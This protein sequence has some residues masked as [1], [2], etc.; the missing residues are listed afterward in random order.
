MKNGRGGNASET[1]YF[2]IK[3]GLPHQAGVANYRMVAQIIP[4]FLKASMLRSVATKEGRWFSSI[5]SL[6]YPDDI[7]SDHRCPLEDGGTTGP[8]YD[9]PSNAITDVPRSTSYWRFFMCSTY[10]VTKVIVF[11]RYLLIYQRM[12]IPQC[13]YLKVKCYVDTR[14]LIH[15][16]VG[17]GRGRNEETCYLEDTDAYL[18]LI[19]FFEQIYSVKEGDLAA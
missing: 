15:V 12:Y 10:S 7:A 1:P 5:P 18:S 13:L 6:N 17:G 4:Y 19:L 11:A 9:H 2:S 14:L 16:W 8:K 3:H